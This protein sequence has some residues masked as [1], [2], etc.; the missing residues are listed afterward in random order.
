MGC[1]VMYLRPHHIC[2]G[3]NL[4]ITSYIRKPFLIYD[5]APDPICISLYMR[6][7]M[8]SFLSVH[9]YSVTRRWLKKTNLYEMFFL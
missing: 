8:F 9:L 6:K 1:K 7:I 3:K 2:M 5:F 4:R